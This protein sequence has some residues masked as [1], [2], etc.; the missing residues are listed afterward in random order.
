MGS[1]ISKWKL[2]PKPK[3]LDTQFTRPF[4]N[5]KK[6]ND[7]K[8]EPAHTPTLEAR[9]ALC[10]HT[11]KQATSYVNLFLVLTKIPRL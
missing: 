1:K 2:P 11:H 6:S 5:H 7:G 3:T 10:G 4:C 9:L 8:M